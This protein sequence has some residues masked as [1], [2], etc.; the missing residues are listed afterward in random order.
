MVTFSPVG[1]CPDA[2]SGRGPPPGRGVYHSPQ[3]PGSQP[4][5]APG[6]DS[7]LVPG[8]ESQVH[9]T[10]RYTFPMNAAS[11]IPAGLNQETLRALPPF[12]N[13]RLANL[14]F[15]N[16]HRVGFPIL[17]AP[18]VG[19]SHVAFRAL[20]RSYLP[21]GCSTLLFTEM[22]S[23]RRLPSERVGSTPLTYVME[24]GEADL[25]P[26]LLANEER[27]ISESVRKL[28]AITPAGIDINMGCPVKQALSHNWGVALMGDIGYAS[29]VVSMARRH[30]R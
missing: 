17:V 27:F 7:A 6:D 21:A 30:V 8:A 16:G 1:D 18:M 26:Q 29:G 10:T 25:V 14:D 4:R 22:L 19:I 5:P 28:E 12:A 3:A 15:R 2:G 23:S 9:S 13:S 20:V 24:E 11:P